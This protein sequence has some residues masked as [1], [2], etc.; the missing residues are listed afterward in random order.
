MGRFWF[1]TWVLLLTA[2]G[3]DSYAP[4]AANCLDYESI[5]PAYAVVETGQTGCWDQTGAV[6]SC[7]ASGNDYG[8]DS[9]Y[10]GKAPS[11]TFCASNAV[12]VDNNTNLMWQAG[13]NARASYSDALAACSALELGGFSDW[14][15]PNI[16]E[17]FTISNFSGSYKPTDDTTSAPSDPYI[18]DDYFSIQYDTGVSLTG[19]HTVQLMGQT[20]SSTVRP[21]DSTHN[22]F[23]NFLDGHLKS[24]PNNNSSHT[25]FYR[26]T[27]GTAV[28]TT[29]SYTNNGDGSV[30]DNVTGLMWQRANAI[31]SGSDYQFEWREALAYCEALSLAGKTDWRLPNIKE[32]QSLV[33]YSNATNAIDTTV[34]T[35]TITASTGPFY[36]SSTSDEFK[37]EFANYVCFGPCYNTSYADVHGPGAQRSEHKYNT[38]SLPTSL[39]DQNDLV[40][41]NN[42][43]RCVRN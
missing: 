37:P 30:T 10:S 33:D 43:V 24:A 22:Y 19:T 12:V 38:G 4:T 41:A 35:N 6:I 42:Y 8:Q 25:Q 20:W 18:F 29:K 15:L 34:F 32:L 7:P 9:Q 14:R 1:G 16:K 40:Q 31:Q 36:W 39:G 5:T 13:H 2:C 3:D 17:L 21:D 26:C 23:F 11:F 27:R 28:A